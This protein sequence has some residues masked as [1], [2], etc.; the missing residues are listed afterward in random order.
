MKSKSK[1][2][3]NGKLVKYG[4]DPSKIEVKPEDWQLGAI[5]SEVL[6]EDGNWSKHLPVYEAQSNE[7]FDSFGCTCFGS[8]NQIEILLNFLEG[9]EYNF[10]ERYP[11]NIVEIEPP[12]ANPNDIYQALR[13]NGLLAQEELPWVATKDEFKSPRPMSDTLIAKGKLW[14]N[15]YTLEHE[16]LTSPTHKQIAE[17]LKYSPIA[18][19][20]TAW[21]EQD[22]LYVDNGQKNSHW[23]VCFKAEKVKE[24]IIL[25]VFDSYNH[26]VKKLHPNHFISFAKKISIKKNDPVEIIYKQ[27]N[28]FVGILKSFLSLFKWRKLAWW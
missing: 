15:D 28:W 11:Y 17:E 26:S 9:K 24:G 20:V 8:L 18:L 7:N 21:F 25:H 22:G 19:S 6:K 3:I 14:L 13:H 23:C 4:F 5:A 2:K 12:G 16:W 1:K 27:N 10:S